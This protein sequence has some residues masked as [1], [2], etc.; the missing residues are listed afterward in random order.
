MTE[1]AIFGGRPVRKKPFPPYISTGEEEKQ[2]VIEVMDSKVLSKFLGE[3]S[4]DFYGGPRVQKLEKEWADYFQVKYAVSVNSATSGLYAAVGASGIGPGDEVI[5]SPYTMSASATAALVYGAIPVFADI[6]PDIFCI[7]PESIRERI[8][9]RTRAIIV[10]D[11]FG[12]PADMD[13][14]ME[15]AEEH[16]LIVIEDAAQA[17]GA[18]YH[19]RYAG[20]LGHM[21]VYS[22]NY[23]KTIQCGEGGVVVTNDEDLAERMRLIR[24][25]AEVVVNHKEVKNLVNLIGFNFRMTE[26]EAAIASEQLKK[27]EKLLI[28]RIQA[29]NY[30]TTHLREYPGLK[31][32]LIRKGVRHGY[33]V[34]PLRY[35]ASVTGVSRE[36]VTRALNAEGIPFDSGYVQPLYLEPVYQQ[37]IA[38]GKNGFPFTYEGYKGTL[39]YKKGLCPVTELM[40]YTEVMTTNICH[41]NITQEDLNNVLEAFEKIFNHIQELK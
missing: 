23:H 39:N 24:N 25:H 16:D 21:G 4:P 28:P 35:D 9:P 27:L 7:T 30:L 32:P 34:Y 13:E 6:D 31:T 18:T 12:H 15:I 41:A 3:W 38:F 10:V 19:G 40:H 33:Y 36:N 11:I 14:I 29:A 2:A 1:L 20:T 5:V 26:I 8:T 17:P 22:L 37:R